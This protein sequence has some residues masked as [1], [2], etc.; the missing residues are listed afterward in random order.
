MP[1]FGDFEKVIFKKI[2]AQNYIAAVEKAR[3]ELTQHGKW[4]VMGVQASN[5]IATLRK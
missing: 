3:R 1:Y 5:M 2:K 4:E